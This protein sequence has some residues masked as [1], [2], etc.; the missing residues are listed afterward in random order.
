MTTPKKTGLMPHDFDE[1][2]AH[3]RAE[4]EAMKTITDLLAPLSPRMRA[5]TL[6]YVQERLLDQQEL[7][8][9]GKVTP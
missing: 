1:V 7:A 5:A 8:A 9:S 4:L 6:R 3:M 2:P